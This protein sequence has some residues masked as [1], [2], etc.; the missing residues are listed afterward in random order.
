MPRRQ[1]ELPELWNG[2]TPPEDVEEAGRA[3]NM[4]ICESACRF[5]PQ[6]AQGF[7]IA[8][9]GCGDVWA[10]VKDRALLY[11]TVH[12]EAWPYVCGLGPNPPEGDGQR[13]LWL[14]AAAW[15]A[16][17]WLDQE[18][19]TQKQLHMIRNLVTNLKA[20]VASLPSG[21]A[22]DAEAQLRE[23]ESERAKPPGPKLVPAKAK[24][25]DLLP[26]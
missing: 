14:L 9:R 25:K 15:R 22:L 26:N 23:D 20:G 3:I 10:R 5:G 8:R 13:C 11:D 4:S 24:K 18:E 2:H 17:T 1:K 21:F 6:D 7:G 19:L 12:P 16:M